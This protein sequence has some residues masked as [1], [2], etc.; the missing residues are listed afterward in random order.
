MG[1][2]LNS[3]KAEEAAA[4]VGQAPGCGGEHQGEA[5]QEKAKDGDKEERYFRRRIIQIPSEVVGNSTTSTRYP[6]VPGIILQ[7]LSHPAM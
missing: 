3:G 5:G 2:I 1:S 6:E 7:V 4:A